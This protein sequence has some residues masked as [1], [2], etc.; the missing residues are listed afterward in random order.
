MRGPG[1]VV[2]VAYVV[3]AAGAFAAVA[4]IAAAA[5]VAVGDTAAVAAG[6][7]LVSWTGQWP[8]A[9]G[10]RGRATTTASRG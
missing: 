10:Q 9:F 6:F 7:A 2:A 3:V 8:R 5:V 4:V 1:A